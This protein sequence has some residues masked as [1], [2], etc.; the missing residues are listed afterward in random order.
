MSQLS[1]NAGYEESSAASC[2]PICR[3]LMN[4]V[5]CAVSGIKY[6]QCSMADTVQDVHFVRLSVHI[7]AQVCI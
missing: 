6:F 7:E 2:C 5:M 3:K 1:A 4:N